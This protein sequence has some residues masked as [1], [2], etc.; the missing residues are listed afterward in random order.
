MT[1][2]DD[3]D[4]NSDR[5]TLVLTRRDVAALLTMPD[6]IGAV[7]SAFRLYGEGRV[8]APS[9]LGVHVHDGGFHVK[10]ATL[11]TYF[12][13][14]LNANFPANP[15]RLGL[16]T[17]QGV[18]ALADARCG[19]L[20]ALMDSIEITA[21]RTAAASAVAAKHLARADSHV[22]T[23][24][25]C[26]VQGPIQLAALRQVLPVTEVWLYDTN[27]RRASDLAAALSSDPTLAVRVATDPE[28]AVARSDV[29]VT[30][31]PATGVILRRAAV[32]AGTF[33]AAVG[34]D[35]PAKQEIEPALMAA[36]T[37]VVDILDQAATMGDLHHAIEAGL[38]TRDQAHAELGDV[39]ARRKP[40]RTSAAEITLFDS[41][42]TALQ[43]VAAAALTYEHALRRGAGI[44]VDFTSGTISDSL[45][46]RSR[47]A[48]PSP[49]RS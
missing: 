48:S 34:A 25:G 35:N 24:W 19:R 14:K 27:A 15:D 49:D 12:A 23:I 2:D 20:L 37:V 3:R 22:V 18:I 16:P 10:A 44:T 13:A 39:V 33:V 31:T 7:E 21:L 4:R 32:R 42:G 36:A 46:S 26:G 47:S 41:T 5:G 28:A 6:C 29:V 45:H 8:S 43:D 30:C 1:G 38:M 11:H 17:I 9:T 40:G